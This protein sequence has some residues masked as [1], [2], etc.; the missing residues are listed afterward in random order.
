MTRKSFSAI[1]IALPVIAAMAGG[2][3]STAKSTSGA[4]TEASAAATVA[5]APAPTTPDWKVYSGDVLPDAATPVFRISNAKMQPAVS[6]I[7]DDAEIAGNKIL[8]FVSPPG[9]DNK[10]CWT[11]DWAA[12]PAWGTTLAFRAKAA[13]ETPGMALVV[14]FEFRDGEFRDRLVGYKDGRL[15]LDKS[16]VNAEFD[17]AA[18]HVFRITTKKADGGMA[19]NVYM[20]ENPAPILSG[21]SAEGADD[22]MFRFGDG[23]GADYASSQYDWIVWSQNGAFGP[24][25]PLPEGLKVQ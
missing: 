6:T 8:Q 9:Q 13:P 22:K 19:V 14:D 3:A 24:E 10:F 17:G 18:W 7:I 21:K 20:D 4:K 15:K 11:S 5:A 1:M 12:N 25:T 23:S 2:C 16:A